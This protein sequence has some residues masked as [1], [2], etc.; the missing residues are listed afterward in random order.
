[1]T[2]KELF[3]KA[4]NGTLTWEQFETAMGD[5]KFVDLGEG[6]Y[7]SKTKY[8]NE[9]AKKDKRIGELTTT[10]SARDADL[11][12]L[13]QTLEDAGDVEALKKASADLAELQQKYDK[14][15]KEYQEQLAQQA[16]EFAVKDFAS[17]KQFS[18]N[19]AKRDFVQSMLAKKLSLE[20]GKIIGAEDFAQI[21]AKDNEDAFVAKKE[22]APKDQ[23]PKFV[24]GPEQ[25]APKKLT[26]SELMKLK[27]ENPDAIIDI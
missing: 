19:A 1:M 3:D 16:Y 26:L 13:K 22:V 12:K 23:K 21:Y 15:T 5:A 6:N 27:N 7:V 11:Q 24:T 8:D 9:I 20:D 14:E 17:T 2:V 18:S 10:I 4:E 25:P